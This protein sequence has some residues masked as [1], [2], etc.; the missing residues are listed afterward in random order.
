M[1]TAYDYF[2]KEM[3]RKPY[4]SSDEHL[5]DCT[6]FL[7]YLIDRT[8]SLRLDFP[9]DVYLPGTIMTDSTAQFYYE[10]GPLEVSVVRAYVG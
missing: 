6:Q 7:D 4:S 5:K 2:N 3:E 8:V 10:L 9:A 1:F